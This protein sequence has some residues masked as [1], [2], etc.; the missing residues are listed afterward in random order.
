M[1]ATVNA[2]LSKSRWP[3]LVHGLALVLICSL[4]VQLYGFGGYLLAVL[5]IVIM[6]AWPSNDQPYHHIQWQDETLVLK[7]GTA[8]ETL[9]WTGYGRRSFA[10]IRLEI[11]DHGK[12]RQFVVWKDQVT[13]ASWRALNMAFLVWQPALIK[14]AK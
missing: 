14:S 6:I 13:D 4:L 10:F 7:T 9:T 5:P 11:L 2:T 12:R 8:S 1:P 3:W